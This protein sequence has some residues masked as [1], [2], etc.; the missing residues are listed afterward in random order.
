MLEGWLEILTGNFPLAASSTSWVHK[1][2][3]TAKKPFNLEQWQRWSLQISGV[4]R[5]KVGEGKGTCPYTLG[6][7][8]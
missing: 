3:G 8:I 6:L 7:G 5:G 2:G 1:L 4:G